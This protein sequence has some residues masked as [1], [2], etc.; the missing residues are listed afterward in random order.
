[1]CQVDVDFLSGPAQDA[2]QEQDEPFGILQ[3]GKTRELAHLLQ[4]RI[5]RPTSGRGLR[6]RL[7]SKTCGPPVK[8]YTPWSSS[9][10]WKQSRPPLWLFAVSRLPPR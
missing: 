4:L 8:R 5:L 6:K 3:N 1:M 7:V 9:R 10:R 2:R